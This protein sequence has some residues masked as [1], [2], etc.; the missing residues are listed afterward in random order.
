MTIDVSK[1]CSDFLRQAY[2]PTKLK[3]SHAR[4]LVAAFFGYKSHAAL[5][6]EKNWPLSRLDEAAVMVPDIPLLDKR[7]TQLE[8]FPENSMS[9]KEVAEIL[10]AFLK[11]EQMFN[12]QDWIYDSLET[13]LMEQYVHDNG[14]IIGDEVSGEMAETNAYFDEIY[15]DDANT[16]EEDGAVV[17]QIKGQFNGEN[18]PDKPFSGDQIDLAIKIT[19][20]RVAGRI[21]FADPEMEVGGSVNDDWVDPELRYGLPVE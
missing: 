14:H 19:L 12:G 10:T 16:T 11:R 18:D 3:A 8:E 1:V 2:A 17:V 13:Y 6:S 4:E 5:L 9:S 15:C 20:P 21:A 7:R